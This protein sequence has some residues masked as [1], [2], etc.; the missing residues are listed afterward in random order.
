MTKKEK[1]LFVLILFFLTTLF[2]PWL[3]LANIFAAIFLGVFSFFFDSFDDSL[4]IR[5]ENLSSS[6]QKKWQ[7]WKERK[8]LWWMFLFFLVVLI[9]VFLSSNFH[10]GLR[11]LDPRLPLAYFPVSVGLLQL[12]KEYKDKILLGFAWL[13]TFIML[14]C[15]CWSLQRSEFFK[16]PEFLYNDSFTEIL[17][18]QSIYISLLVNIS[19]YIFG[20]HILYK[21]NRYKGWM[22]LTVIFLFGTSYLLASR[23]LMLVL[24]VVTIGFAF[25]YIFKKKKYLEGAALLLGLLLGLFMIFKFFPKTFNRYKELAYTQFDYKNMGKESHYNMEVTKDQWNGANFRMAAW[26]C[27]WELFLTSPIKGVDIG[28]KRDVLMD[29]YR[30]KDFQFALKTQKNV[31]NNYLDILYSMGLIGLSCFLVGWVVLPLLFAKRHK[32]WLGTLIILTFV[33]AWVTE[34]YF[35]RSLGGMLTG[36]FIP[37]L[38]TDE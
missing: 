8:Y 23:N 15:L 11:Y 21:K 12:K 31:H 28:D 9:S 22:I 30:E 25:F 16:K 35:D 37:F 33:I 4:V 34:I 10:K 17:K 20:Y 26:R 7:L 19:I 36:F 6:F 13:T 29:K 5:R 24:Y 32:D 1:V 14:L 38:L 2:L 3:K 18:Q 27:G